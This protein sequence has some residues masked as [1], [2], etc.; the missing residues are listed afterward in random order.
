VSEAF[1]RR[2]PNPYIEVFE[3][4]TAGPNARPVPRV[5]IWAEVNEELS[6]AAQR[7]YL[8]EMEPAEALAVA[9]ER[10]QK[11]YDRYLARQRARR[12]AAGLRRNAAGPRCGGTGPGPAEAQEAGR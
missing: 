12:E 9:Q 8:M 6:V 7:V 5:P 2:H 10:L 11:K 1:I 3:R 4:M